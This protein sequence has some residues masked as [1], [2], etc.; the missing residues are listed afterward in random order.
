MRYLAVFFAN[1]ALPMSLLRYIVVTLVVVLLG[2]TGC[3]RAPGPVLRAYHVDCQL[4]EQLRRDSVSMWMLDDAYGQLRLC[5]AARLEN[6]QVRFAGQIEQPALAMLKWDNDSTPF[7]FVLEPG[8][9][10]LHIKPDK[11]IVAG[12]APQTKRYALLLT[13]VHAI[14]QS[15][16][17]L[18]TRYSRLAADTALRQVDEVNLFSRD[19][20]MRDSAQD[21]VVATINRGDIASRIV[22]M[23]FEQRLDSLHRNAIKIF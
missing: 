5:G 16:S 22:K 7:L 17:E 21:L 9:T 18:W 10:R 3:Q 15:R 8:D 23:R 13:Q 4:D 6:G 20:V 2:A 19:S 12:R 11:W 14:E 1:F